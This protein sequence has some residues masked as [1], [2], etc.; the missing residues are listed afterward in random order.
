MLASRRKKRGKAAPWGFFTTPSRAAPVAARGELGLPNLPH[1]SHQQ[2]FS[3]TAQTH[4]PGSTGPWRCRSPRP[5][6]KQPR[7]CRGVGS[8][9]AGTEDRAA[10]SAC[11]RVLV[12]G[13]MHV[14]HT[15]T[16][17]AV[18]EGQSR[19]HTAQSHPCGS[20]QRCGPRRK[21]G[22]G[23]CCC[24]LSGRWRGLT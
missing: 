14:P 1:P 4:L 20:P 7:P 21:A 3:R 10:R 15:S 13:S 2:L 5:A 12:S 24:A 6:C 19:A 9:E 23:C 16:G 18:L 22:I 11:W 17:R 8:G